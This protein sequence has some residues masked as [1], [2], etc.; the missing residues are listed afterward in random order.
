MR[1][2][3]ESLFSICNTAVTTAVK[4]TLDMLTRMYC[5]SSNYRKDLGHS[6]YDLEVGVEFRF[7]STKPSFGY[8]KD[9][10]EFKKKKKMHIG[11][12]IFIY[13]SKLFNMNVNSQA[14]MLFPMFYKKLNDFSWKVV[15]KNNS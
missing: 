10:F 14:W 5:V 1:K 12:F 11:N 9:I 7:E 15:A 4:L 6:I 3:V 2:Q 13:K 8:I